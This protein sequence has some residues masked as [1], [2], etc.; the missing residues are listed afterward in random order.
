M[1]I[2]QRMVPVTRPCPVDLRAVSEHAGAK[3]WFCGHCDKHVHALSNMTEREVRGLFSDHAGEHLCVSY[4]VLDDGTLSMLPEA[5]VVPAQALRRPRMAFAA[6]AATLSLAACTTATAP[7]RDAR[8]DPAWVQ[9]NLEGE[10]TPTPPTPN[11]AVLPPA[12]DAVLNPPATDAVL[13]P[14]D[15]DAT[16]G[17]PSPLDLVPGSYVRGEAPPVEMILGVDVHPEGDAPCDDPPTTDD[18]P[19]ASD[20][21]RPTHPEASDVPKRG[22]VKVRPAIPGGITV[23][24]ILPPTPSKIG[25]A[26]IADPQGDGF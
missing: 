11:A 20:A 23:P 6:A 14:S 24:K 16:S 12:S 3:R 4:S 15:E 19:P 8:S 26:V 13:N 22:K 10:C 1:S 18:P 9:T 21:A 7:D 2:E 17:V 5:S 25:G